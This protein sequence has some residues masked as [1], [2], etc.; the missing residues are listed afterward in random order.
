MYTKHIVALFCF[1]LLCDVV[2]VNAAADILSQMMEQIQQV[3]SSS[4]RYTAT[5]V[6]FSQCNGYSKGIL[7]PMYAMLG[8][9]PTSTD[10]FTL[11]ITEPST[12]IIVEGYFNP[13]DVLPNVCEFESGYSTLFQNSTPNNSEFTPNLFWNFN[14]NDYSNI[15]GNVL[16][17]QHSCSLQ[18]ETFVAYKTNSA[19]LDSNF[20]KIISL[21]PM[22]YNEQ[23]YSL[24]YNSYG[25]LVSKGK[26]GGSRIETI[27]KSSNLGVNRDSSKVKIVGGYSEKDKQ[28]WSYSVYRNPTM[29]DVELIRM[30][31]FIRNLNLASS[32]VIKN[33]IRFEKSLLT[34]ISSRDVYQS[35]LEH[36]RPCKNIIL[37]NMYEIY[38]H[39]ACYVPNVY[40][41][42]LISRTFGY[43]TK[44][45]NIFKYGVMGK[46]WNLDLKCGPSET[47]NFD[48]NH[49]SKFFSLRS[50][51]EPPQY[52]FT[53]PVYF[54]LNE[55]NSQ[56]KNDYRHFRE[57]A[58]YWKSDIGSRTPLGILGYCSPV[59]LKG[60]KPLNLYKY[61]INEGFGHYLSIY[62]PSTPPLEYNIGYTYPPD[63]GIVQKQIES[64]DPD[65]IYFKVCVELETD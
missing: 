44:S 24:F 39:Y 42:E 7:P 36:N 5:G 47:M 43:Q 11:P 64:G 2:A 63:T 49:K 19:N 25:P 59:K 21:L 52:P 13:Q 34:S 18:S 40:T 16:D 46:V 53:R 51:N 22:E 30:S 31:D 45:E 33:M 29:V 14:T 26:Y 60:M 58:P 56:N 57:A 54:D 12:N 61:S 8:Y 48:R 3:K 15:F 50:N 37:S 9:N 28:S 23:V 65:L 17:I 6:D 35:I 62:S 32:K 20:K 55:F 41:N 27:V 10:L 4:C 38:I 1:V